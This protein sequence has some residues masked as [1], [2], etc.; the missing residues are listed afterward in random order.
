MV[1][2]IFV[3]IASLLLVYS[4]YLT[5]M[6]NYNYHMFKNELNASMEIVTIRD[7]PEDVIKRIMRL[8]DE[9]D[10]PISDEDI[11]LENVGNLYAVRM[12][13]E[14]TVNFFPFYVLYQKTYSY[15]IDTGK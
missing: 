5:F 9:Y 10:I 1:K 3:V 6:P 2:N 13:W 14:D 7:K 11:E 15:H 8:V 12:S 4:F